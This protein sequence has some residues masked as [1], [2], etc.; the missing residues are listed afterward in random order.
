MFELNGKVAIIT[1][2]TAW[3]GR[4]MAESF[5]EHGCDI[6]ITSRNKAKADKAASEIA[7][8]YGVK[9]IGLELE[10]NSPESVEAMAKNALKCRF[11][12]GNIPFG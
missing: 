8:K 1:G 5:A 2:A 6:I 4:D 3:L 9:A 7:E 10:V 11:N 12:G